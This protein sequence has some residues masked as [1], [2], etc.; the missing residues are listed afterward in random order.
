MK[1]EKLL[2]NY[3]DNNVN[4][5]ALKQVN[6]ALAEL[7][8]SAFIILEKRK[9]TDLITDIILNV[10]NISGIY[11]FA[12]DQYGYV[13]DSV[14]LKNLKKQLGDINED[15]EL[16][17]Y[18][19]NIILEK[20]NKNKLPQDFQSISD[21]LKM[22][23]FISNQKVDIY[24][25]EASMLVFGS[26]KYFENNVKTKVCGILHDYLVS[27]N[28]DFDTTNNDEILE[29]FHIISTEYEMR[30]KGNI[31]IIFKDGMKINVSELK[32]GFSFSSED[33]DLIEHIFVYDERFITIENKTSFLRFKAD[34]T[35]TFYLGGFTNH[36]ETLLLRKIYHENK[37]LRY[38]HFG[39]I[40]IGGFKILLNLRE[41]TGI[42]FL[43]FHMGIDE[44]SNE[45]Y[46]SCRQKLSENDISNAKSIVENSLIGN[47]ISYMLKNNVK[48]EQEIVSYY[49]M[50]EN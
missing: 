48:L 35:S 42:D 1:P 5:E 38:F 19:Y 9:N 24:Q 15:S 7:E 14:Q 31:E 16:V 8:E 6:S 12:S 36:A 34:E 47:I 40:D 3:A 11:D 50:Q 44:L 49:L 25:R 43:P 13:P 20:V 21:I 18:Y 17:S 46:A 22:L 39:D 33:M 32:N 4:Y 2:K 27:K 29:Q 10:E 30:L 26:S 45:K 23:T 37:A 41:V 28:S